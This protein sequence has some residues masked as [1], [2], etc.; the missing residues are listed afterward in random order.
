VP[1]EKKRIVLKK[2]LLPEDINILSEQVIKNQFD[3]LIPQS[4][5]FGGGLGGEALL[6]QFLCTWSRNTDIPNLYTYITVENFNDGFDHLTDRMSGLVAMLMADSIYLQNGES[7]ISKKEAFASTENKMSQLRTQDFLDVFKGQRVFF[8]SLK[9]S[10]N[11]G[12]I[13]P[14]YNGKVVSEHGK[15][16][17]LLYTFFE[18]FYKKSLL[19]KDNK[20]LINLG[21]VA[22]QLFLNTHDHARSDHKGNV[23]LKDARGLIFN[24]QSFERQDLNDILSDSNESNK[25][26]D[27]LFTRVNGTKLSFI[28][29]SV[30][31]SGE[32]LTNN[33]MSKKYNKNIND[34]NE[35][36]EVN[37][38]IECFEKHNTTKS[39]KS[40]GV[41]LSTIIESLKGVS[42]MFRLRTSKTVTNWYSDSTINNETITDKNITLCKTKIVGTSFTVL[43]PILTPNKK[44]F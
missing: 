38:I 41:G 12:L 29:I 8:P 17:Y 6:I 15:F 2:S 34:I 3:L 24:K 13:P 31:D 27:F 14:L 16:K 20:F 42:G 22:H 32:G 4:I 33:W 1:P 43:V 18:K 28:E 25:Y 37:S 11:G 44:D 9:P 35:V 10:K 30:V 7:S 39:T 36:D 19:H 21:N 23:Y 40:S 5:A 26:L